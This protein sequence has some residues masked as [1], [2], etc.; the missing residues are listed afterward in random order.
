MDYTRWPQAAPPD[1]RDDTWWRCPY[2]GHDGMTNESTVHL[3]RCPWPQ[4]EAD[5][6]EIERLRAVIDRCMACPH[7]QCKE[8]D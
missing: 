8:C 6:L 1:V 2:C 7:R 4:L 3:P 5:R